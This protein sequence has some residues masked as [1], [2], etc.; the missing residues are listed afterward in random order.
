LDTL[1][2]LARAFGAI[3]QASKGI[4]VQKEMARI[5]RDTG[6]N[7]LFTQ[8]VDRLSK[9]A[10]NDEGVR[11]LMSGSGSVAPAP[12][13]PAPPPPQQQQYQARGRTEPP[14][15]SYQAV[16]TDDLIPEE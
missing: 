13:T 14:E 8:L 4:E 1:A 3:G 7:E 6:K 15:P 10:P 9:V 11:K 5:A 16:E 12:A 2:L